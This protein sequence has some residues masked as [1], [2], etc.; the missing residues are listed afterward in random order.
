MYQGDE[1]YSS[2]N[3]VSG[4]YPGLKVVTASYTGDSGAVINSVLTGSNYDISGIDTTSGSFALNLRAGWNFG[5]SDEST[6]N[7][8]INPFT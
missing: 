1:W 8:T 5:I 4:L 3:Y 6:M 7:I 2:N